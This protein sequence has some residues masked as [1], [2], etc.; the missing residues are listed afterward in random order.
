MENTTI[1]GYV[2]KYK[3]GEGGMA[4]VW[5]AENSLQMPAAIKVLQKDFA[6]TLSWFPVSKMKPN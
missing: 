5:Y 2:L 1:S 4:E 6:A 3:L